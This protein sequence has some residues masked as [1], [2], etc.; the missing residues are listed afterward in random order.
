LRRPSRVAVWLLAASALTGCQTVFGGGMD[1]DEAS[2][3]VVRLV[4]EALDAGLAGKARPE[5]LGFGPHHCT[6]DLI[7]P[8]GEVR[9]NLHYTFHYTALGIDSAAFAESAT[10][11]WLANGMRVTD[12]DRPRLFRRFAV[13][14][15]GFRIRLTINEEID[16]ITIS[17]SGPCVDPPD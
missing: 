14:E 3:T 4:N 7:G 15:D 9:P 6:D 16:Q 1:Y 10:E 12:Q 8:T 17:G 13:S 5:P 2:D 11:S